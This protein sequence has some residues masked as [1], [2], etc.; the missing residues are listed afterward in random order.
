MEVCAINKEGEGPPARTKDPIKA[1]NP[2]SKYYN[3]LVNKIEIGS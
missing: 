2:Y 3:D 1:E